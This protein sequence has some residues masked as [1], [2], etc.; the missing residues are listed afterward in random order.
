MTDPLP[1]LVAVSSKSSFRVRVHSA[2]WSTECGGTVRRY[3]SERDGLV[4]LSCTG[5]D[6]ATKA[7]R[8]LLHSPDIECE[9]TIESDDG[10]TERLARA[11]FADK[12]VAYQAACARLALGAVHLTALAKI[13]GLLPVMDD[14]HLWA[15]LNS[16]R[17]TTPLLRHWTGWLKRTMIENGTITMC[18]GI[19]A[20]QAGILTTDQSQL[21]EM[22]SEGVRNGYLRMVA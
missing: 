17:F 6:T 11:R 7:I 9:F 20:A 19:G 15:E 2:A 3:V 18:E 1:T 5:P 16:P 8:A 4:L 21:D 14:S 22:V 12:P 10:T 13:P